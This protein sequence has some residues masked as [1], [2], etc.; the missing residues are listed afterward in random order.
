M[1]QID[2]SLF[3]VVI[4]TPRYPQYYVRINEKGELRLSSKLM[5]CFLGKQVLVLSHE[6]E[7]LVEEQLQTTED[8]MI[9]KKSGNRVN[10]FASQLAAKGYVFPVIYRGD[11]P[12]GGAFY[13]KAELPPSSDA[14]KKNS[15]RSKKRN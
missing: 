12:E 13:G 4:E 9:I 10:E 3:T 1:Q 2:R 6:N 14:P 11:R 8:S 7:L 5:G 15:P